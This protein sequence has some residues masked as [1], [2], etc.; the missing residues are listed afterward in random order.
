[1]VAGGTEAG[2]SPGRSRPLDRFLRDVFSAVRVELA[3]S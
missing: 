3:D 2:A 1:M